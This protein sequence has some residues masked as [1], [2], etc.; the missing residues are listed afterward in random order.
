M[1]L[2]VCDNLETTRIGIIQPD[3][4]KTYIKEQE[5]D[6]GFLMNK[7]TSNQRPL[8]IRFFSR[9]DDTLF[10]CEVR[11]RKRLRESV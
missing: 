2:Q 9:S 11:R 7:L 3:E 5:K 1:L 6:R 8:L 4:T 10:F